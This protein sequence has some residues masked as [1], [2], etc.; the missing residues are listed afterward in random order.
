MIY[1]SGST[2]KPKGVVISSESLINF[3]LSMQNQFGLTLKDRLL[4]VTTIAFDISVLEIFLPLVSGAS[5]LIATKETVQD[6]KALTDMLHQNDITIMQATPTLWHT[7]VTNYPSQLQG[8]RV[9]VGERH[10]N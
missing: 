7:L 10:F 9:L 2:G 1:T 3:L 4:A 8:L 5:C 6:P